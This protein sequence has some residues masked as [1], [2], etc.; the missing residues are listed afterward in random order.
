MPEARLRNLGHVSAEMLREID[1]NSAEE[2]RD[3]GR[4]KPI[5]GCDSPL[6]RGPI[7]TYFLLLWAL[8]RVEIGGISRAAKKMRD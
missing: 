6:A 3:M 5:A 2:L 7:R 1:V 4:W 8:W